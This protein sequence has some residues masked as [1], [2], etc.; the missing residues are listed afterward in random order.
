MSDRINTLLKAAGLTETSIGSLERGN[1]IFVLT[2]QTLL[3][4]DDT[5]TRRVT[6]RDLT[7][8]HSDQEGTLRVETPAGTAL[9]ASLL[10]FD[11]VH[12]QGFFKQVRDATAKAKDPAPIAQAPTAQAPA[13]TIPAPST[14]APS[15][16]APSTSASITPPP[17]AAPTS[18]HSAPT[19][20]TATGP[21]IPPARP[22]QIPAQAP[23]TPAATQPGLPPKNPPKPVTVTNLENLPP[24]EESVTIISADGKRGERTV[25]QPL[26]DPVAAPNVPKDSA[27]NAKERLTITPET[28]RASPATVTIPPVASAASATAKEP[29]NPLPKTTAVTQTAPA[30]TMPNQGDV[31]NPAPV[32]PPPTAAGRVP[33]SAVGVLAALAAQAENV[34]AWIGRLRFLGVFMLLAALALAYLLF[35]EGQGLSAVWTLIAGGL[36]SIALMALADLTKLLVGLSRAV[37][38]EGGVMDVD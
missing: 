23:A 18:A 26:P 9:T 17:A 24:I 25:T 21:T 11:P 36:S 10:G 34:N 2:P 31:V 27:K 8:V 22:V 4:Q 29:A 7:R 5:G 16:S 14:S 15:T 33:Q 20:P 38:A 3:Y 19:T 30:Q 1:A 37:S 35:N 28:H 32:M 6:L 13:P 12:V